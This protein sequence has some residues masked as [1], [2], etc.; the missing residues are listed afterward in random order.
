MSFFSD[1][2]DCKCKRF[3]QIYTMVKEGHFNEL[4]LLE[5]KEFSELYIDLNKIGKIQD[6]INKDE[7]IHSK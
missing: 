4:S 5:K 6:I 3:E 1:E 2:V 7:P